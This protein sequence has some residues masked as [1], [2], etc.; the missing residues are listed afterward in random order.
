MMLF[1]CLKDVRFAP[2]PAEATFASLGPAA[3]EIS[4]ESLVRWIL[5][6]LPP[7]TE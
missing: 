2:F 1:L 7:A 3:G 4:E 6:K 5:D